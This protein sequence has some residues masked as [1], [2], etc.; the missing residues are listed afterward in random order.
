MPS[1]TH[2]T[3]GFIVAPLLFGKGAAQKCR[4][5]LNSDVEVDSTPEQDEICRTSTDDLDRQAAAKIRI[6]GRVEPN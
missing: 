2:Q 3:A 1:R 5:A 6:M 4:L